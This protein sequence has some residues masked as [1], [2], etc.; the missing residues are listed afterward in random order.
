MSEISDVPVEVNNGLD[1]A[2]TIGGEL[3]LGDGQVMRGSDPTRIGGLKIKYNGEKAPEG[4]FA[5]TVTLAQNSGVYQIGPFP[6]Q[7]T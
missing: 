2:G 5:G 1:V 4:E 7:A 6:D 3:A